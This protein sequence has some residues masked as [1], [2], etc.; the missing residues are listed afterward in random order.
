MSSTL[1]IPSRM[2]TRRDL[3]DTT[4]AYRLL[5]WDTFPD[6]HGSIMTGVG[7]AFDVLTFPETIAAAVLAELPEAPMFLDV[8][9]RRCAI[10]TL[11]ALDPLADPA[12]LAAAR[13]RV[14]PCR[15]PVMLPILMDEA[16]DGHR[17]WLVDPATS[18]LPIRAEVV[19]VISRAIGVAR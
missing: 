13:V 8:R 6:E 17:R 7:E 19:A 1:D 12:D 5:G 18:T 10:L 2:P 4:F 3:L 9:T 11:V 16:W 14:L 15:T